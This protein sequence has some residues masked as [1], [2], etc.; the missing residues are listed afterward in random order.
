MRDLRS[1][2]GTL[3]GREVRADDAS[4]AE[5]APDVDVAFRLLHDAVNAREPSPVPSPD[6]FVVKKGS[7]RCVCVVSSIPTPVSDTSSRT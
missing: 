3:E 4:A 2:R 7:K 1:Q 6:G 5:T